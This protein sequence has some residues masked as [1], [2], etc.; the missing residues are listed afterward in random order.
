[1]LG[2]QAD[3]RVALVPELEHAALSDR[4]DQNDVLRVARD[5]APR[6][7]KLPLERRVLHLHSGCTIESEYSESTWGTGREWAS[8]SR[9]SQWDRLHHF[10]RPLDQRHED[11]LVR[12]NQQPCARRTVAA[13]TEPVCAGVCV[14]VC[15]HACTC[16]CVFIVFLRWNEE[17]LQRQ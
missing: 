7:G 4:Q 8:P 9:Q 11:A 3:V 15:V 6:V 5:Y 17:G 1:M 14:C 10:V 13:H 2:D 16:M 12:T